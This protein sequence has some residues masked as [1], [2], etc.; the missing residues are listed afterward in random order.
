MCKSNNM[1]TTYIF[2]GDASSILGRNNANNYD[3]NRNFPDQYG[4]N[5]VSRRQLSNY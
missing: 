4:V 5:E 2:L 1:F 3:L